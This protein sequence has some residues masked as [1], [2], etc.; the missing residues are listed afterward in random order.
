MFVC[1][2]LCVLRV[3]LPISL[4]KQTNT[5]CIDGSLSQSLICSH[6][7]TCL[8]WNP[9]LFCLITVW[10][11]PQVCLIVSRANPK[12]DSLPLCA[13]RWECPWHDCSVCG[14]SASSL[15]DFCPSSFCPE[16][17]IGALV[18]S[19]LEGRLCC[20]GHDPASPL[21]SDSSSAQ[22]HASALSPIRVKEEQEAELGEEAEPA[23]EWHPAS[24]AQYLKGGWV[25]GAPPLAAVV[26]PQTL[27]G[28]CSES[29]VS[30]GSLPPPRNTTQQ[31]PL[32]LPLPLP[33]HPHPAPTASTR[34]CFIPPP[35]PLH[36]C[37]SFKVL[38]I[39]FWRHGQHV[40]WERWRWSSRILPPRPPRHP[41]T[42]VSPAVSR[43][44]VTWRHVTHRT[45]EPPSQTPSWFT[46]AA[47]ISSCFTQWRVREQNDWLILCNFFILFFS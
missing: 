24:G 38:A 36:G 26:D 11:E 21:G 13:G 18:P 34:L 43:K 17:E 28:F 23:A 25:E 29:R 40:E 41:H 19:S 7:V 27:Q 16:H 6:C 46:P 8:T 45:S 4:C 42:H 47:F 39:S 31:A 10:V 22:P 5:V 35:T 2:H 3:L 12:Q 9:L 15:C 33:L 37:G 20:S 14:V 1:V 32:S 44:S 30:W